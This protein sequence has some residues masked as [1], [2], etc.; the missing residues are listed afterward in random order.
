ML[1]PSYR[2]TSAQLAMR[3]VIRDKTRILAYGGSRSGKTF[4]FCRALI[5]LG[6][7]Y[8]GRHAIFRRYFNSARRSVF[9]DT[10]PKAL[11][12]CFPKLSYTRNAVETRYVLPNGA[13]YY[14][15]GLDDPKRA[16]KILGL[17]FA[18]V[19]FNE[20]SEIA[21]PAVEL[22]LTR[23]A[24]RRVDAS[25]KVLR[26]RAFFDCNPPGRSHWIYRMFFDKVNPGS[27]TPLYD[28]ENYGVVKL[29]P[30]DNAENLPVGYV[31]STLNCGSE[32][33]K[34]RFLYGEFANDS[35]NA[36]WKQE[37]ID[38]FRTTGTPSGFEK[39]V[40]G[41]DPAVTASGTSDETG[42]VVVGLRT[43]SDGLGHFYVL[44][45]RSL[46]AHPAVWTA[47]VEATRRVWNAD[48]VV[49]E[50]NQG[51]E[52][53]L[54]ALR[55]VNQY[56]PLKPVRA[57]RGKWS[58]AEPAAVLYRQGRVHHVGVFRA[59]EDEMTS[60]NPVEKFDVHDDRVDALAWAISALIDS[61]GACEGG[62][63]RF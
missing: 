37:D 31:E 51:G 45:D 9:E 42:I 11:E 30:S 25:G 22:A 52:L 41:V 55:S 34:K 1:T 23:L 44:D 13:E 63:I 58:R 62:F 35:E 12:L 43:E 3:R 18:T 40:V 54:E 8:G 15:V 53:A 24:E 57:A 36:L 60:F 21:F 10:F 50:T 61:P 5:A 2:P 4:E 20:C 48:L 49:V 6:A 14:F 32:L 46:R 56:M 47:E 39:I 26:N 38:A 19:Y 33:A 28:P 59:L 17:E 29:N 16:E 27:R 7:R